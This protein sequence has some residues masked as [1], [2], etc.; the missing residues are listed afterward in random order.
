MQR[1]QPVEI[2]QTS[3]IKDKWEANVFFK[4]VSIV[5]GVTIDR[6]FHT[7]MLA[8][9]KVRAKSLM[10]GKV[11]IELGKSSCQIFSLEWTIDTQLITF[12]LKRNEQPDSR[13]VLNGWNLPF[14]PETYRK[15][16]I[17]GMSYFLVKY[18]NN[19]RKRGI[20]RKK[21]TKEERKEGRREAFSFVTILRK[22]RFKGQHSIICFL[23]DISLSFESCCFGVR[24]LHSNLLLIYLMN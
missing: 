14:F 8:R 3:K 10:E 6:L 20:K 1:T 9:P 15:W 11:W 18:N 16:G 21:R 12:L 24:L 19:S 13:L 5:K 23:L 7:T 2:G 22:Y 17:F 4:K